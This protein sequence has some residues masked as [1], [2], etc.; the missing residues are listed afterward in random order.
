MKALHT[1]TS[2]PAACVKR[3][4]MMGPELELFTQYP[5][6]GGGSDGF[7]CSGTISVFLGSTCKWCNVVIGT[8]LFHSL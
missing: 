2:L 7:H 6:S 4:K 3:R 5:C 8:P 1:C